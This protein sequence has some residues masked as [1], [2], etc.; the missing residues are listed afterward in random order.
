MKF[1][2]T[3]LSVAITAALAAGQVA[4]SDDLDVAMDVVD[5]V[6]SA[7]TFEMPLG[8]DQVGNLGAGDQEDNVADVDEQEHDTDLQGHDVDEQGDDVDEQGEN[9]SGDQVAGVDA[10]GSGDDD[11]DADAADSASNGQ[12]SNIHEG[13]DGQ[14]GS[15]GGNDAGSGP[16][17]GDSQ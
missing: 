8:G 9:E 15:H 11:D 14:G 3:L 4:A 17:S 5:S 1:Q 16:G 12:V 10:H 13:E 6:D 2:M 7:H